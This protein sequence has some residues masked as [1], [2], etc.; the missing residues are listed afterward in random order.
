MPKGEERGGR[1]RAFFGVI[2]GFVMGPVPCGTGP[3]RRL[4]PS[5]LV[6]CVAVL[7]NRTTTNQTH[8]NS[9]RSRRREGVVEQST[10]VPSWAGL[11]VSMMMM[12]MMTTTA[13]R[14]ENHFFAMRARAD[15]A[16]FCGVLA[17]VLYWWAGREQRERERHRHGDSRVK[18]RGMVDPRGARGRFS[19]ERAYD[20]C[21][22]LHP[23]TGVC[24]CAWGKR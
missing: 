15:R 10:T 6:A 11:P 13:A 17:A 3:A 19:C 12:M 23:P 2:F 18:S 16:A 1:E 8:K 4:H 20:V 5:S 14:Q 22:V 9:N 24:V 7:P 21:Y